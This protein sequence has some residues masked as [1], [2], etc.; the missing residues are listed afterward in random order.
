MHRVRWRAQ[1]PVRAVCA[2]LSTHVIRSSVLDV[3]TPSPP[4]ESF[5]SPLIHQTLSFFFFH[6]TLSQTCYDRHDIVI[7]IVYMEIVEKR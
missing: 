5:G 6:Q 3:G 7:D 2:S 1:Q 4:S